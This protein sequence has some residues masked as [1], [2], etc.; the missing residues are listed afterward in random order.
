MQKYAVI[1]ERKYAIICR[2]MR[3]KI[4]SKYAEMCSKMQMHICSNMLLYAV[5]CLPLICIYMHVIC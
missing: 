2:Y 5:I 4:C 3:W 1:C